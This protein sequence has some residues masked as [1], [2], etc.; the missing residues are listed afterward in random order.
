[1]MQTYADGA[2]PY[3]RSHGSVIPFDR[4]GVSLWRVAMVVVLAMFHNELISVLLGLDVVMMQQAGNLALTGLSALCFA[5]LLNRG[6]PFSHPFM[7][8]PIILFAVML[9]VSLF[10]NTIFFPK[11]VSHWAAAHYVYLPVLQVYILI[12]LRFNDK[13]VIW[14]LIIAG[15]IAALLMI[16]Y[17]LGLLPFLRR[18]VRRSVF[19]MDVARIVIMKYEFFFASLALFAVVLSSR[20]AAWWKGIALALLSLC[21]ALQVDLVQSRQGLVAMGVGIVVLLAI[22]QRTF[23]LRSFLTRAAVG[24]CGVMVAPIILQPYIEMLFRDDLLHSQDLNVAVRLHTFE[25]YLGIFM[26]TNGVGFGMMSPSGRVN[27]VIAESL[28]QFVNYT[29]SGLYGAFFQFG[30]VGGAV[31]VYL[32]WQ[33]VASGYRGARLFP[34]GE[35][36]R[37]AVL[38]AYFIGWLC[39]PVPINAF[40]FQSSIHFGTFVIFLVWYYRSRIRYEKTVRQ[41]LPGAMPD[42]QGGALVGVS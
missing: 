29:D 40:T 31:A 21:L 19:G 22:D 17:E 35:R 34:D 39:V 6:V 12:A 9:T 5:W 38:S 1:M 14:G 23:Q 42:G 32:T 18:Y 33:A 30:I 41:P 27:N 28:A 16:G 26:D 8:W 11:P 36:W 37:P 4:P 10:A 20:I 3:E 13:D 15:V 25:H 24:L 2:S 7:L